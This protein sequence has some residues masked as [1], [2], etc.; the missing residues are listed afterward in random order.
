MTGSVAESSILPQS[1]SFSAT[2]GIGLEVDPVRVLEIRLVR[3]TDS[4]G[5]PTTVKVSDFDYFKL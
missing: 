5:T 1:G 3:S 2:I 4:S